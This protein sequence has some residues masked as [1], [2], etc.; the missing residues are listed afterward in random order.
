M[1]S[2][3]KIARSLLLDFTSLPRS[4]MIGLIPFSINCNAANSPAGPAPI[5]I[6]LVKEVPAL[7][8]M[9]N[10]IPAVLNVAM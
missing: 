7:I 9:A 10:Y 5:I 8:A 1:P 2:L 6:A 3:F 4:R